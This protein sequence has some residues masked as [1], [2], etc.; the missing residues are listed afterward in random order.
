MLAQLDKR[1]LKPVTYRKTVW[2]FKGFNVRICP[3]EMLRLAFGMQPILAPGVE[4]DV[5]EYVESLS[6][7]D[8]EIFKRK[9]DEWVLKMQ[10]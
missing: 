3:F 4:I 10:Q 2:E 9:S 7:K 5:D 8:K 6:N 1:F